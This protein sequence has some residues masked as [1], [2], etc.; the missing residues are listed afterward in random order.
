MTD[1]VDPFKAAPKIVDPFKREPQASAPASPSRSRGSQRK[2][3]QEIAEQRAAQVPE[4]RVVR[5]IDTGMPASYVE[6]QLART[7]EQAEAVADRVAK[8]NAPQPATIAANG[9]GNVGQRVMQAG[10]GA[11]AG[12]LYTAEPILNALGATDLADAAFDRAESMDRYATAQIEGDVGIQEVDSVGDA[13]RFVAQAIPGSLAYMMS[14]FHPAGM[15]ALVTSQTG[16]IGATRAENDGRSGAE[17]G[18]LAIAAPFAAGSVSLDRLGVNR[19][20][21]PA[22]SF[23]GGLGRAAFTE[24]VTEGA[25]GALEYI[26][27]TAGTEAGIDPVQLGWTVAGNTLAGTGMGPAM[28]APIHG[29]QVLQQRVAERQQERA[30]QEAFAPIADDIAR[31][32][33]APDPTLTEQPALPAPKPMADAPQVGAPAAPAAEPVAIVDPF[34]AEQPV[35]EPEPAPTV[36]PVAEPSAEQAAPAEPAPVAVPEPEPAPAPEPAPV[37]APEPAPS[38]DPLRPE[39]GELGEGERLVR[40]P[41]GAQ[42]RTR[43]EVV[44]ASQLAQAEGANQNRDRSRETTDLQVQ[45]II[46]RFDPEQLHEDPSSDRGAPI[47][48][49][50]GA[51]DSG[52]GRVLTLNRIYDAHPDLAAKY[53]AMIEGRGFSTDGMERPV[54]IQ[55]RVTDMTPE[56]RRQFVIDSNKDT[57]LELSPTERARGDADAI[58]PE[59][60]AQYAGGDLNGTANSGFVQAFNKRLTTAELGN[61]I[62]S[63]RRLTT[64]G[65]Q[66]IE[67][68]I[69]AAAFDK[70]KLLERMMESAQ[71][72]IRSITGSLAD[73]A[74]NW[75]RM[76]QDIAAGEVG[77]RYDIT[78]QL[79]DAAARVSDAR[80]RGTKPADII[81]QQDAFDQIDD[82]TEQLIRAFHNPQ[83]TRA[84]SRKAVSGILSDY[85]KIAREQKETDGLFGKE[86]GKAP[87]DI[88]RELLEQRDNPNAGQGL[89]FDSAGTPIAREGRTA[90]RRKRAEPAELDEEGDADSETISYDD[91]R[92]DAAIEDRSPYDP[93]FLTASFTNRASLFHTAAEYLGMDP[94][95]FTLLPAPRQVALLRRVMFERFGVAIKVEGNLQE[96]FAIDQ[97]L[98]AFQNVQA[99]AHILG[100]PNTAVGLDGK[101]VIQ[102]QKGGGYLGAFAPDSNT[103]LL[104]KRT[105]SFAHEWGHALDFFLM[106][107]SGIFG[108]GLTGAI[109]QEGAGAT[110]LTDDMQGSLVRL[111]NAMF[112]DEAEMAAKI[113]QLEA[114]IE[115]SKSPKVKA[116]LQAQ[117]DR[118]KDGSSQSRTARSN[119]YRGAQQADGG[120]RDY[121]TSPTEMF[122]RAFEAYVSYK[123]EEAGLTTE[124]I[125]KGDANY[126][127]NAEDRFRLTFPKDRERAAIFAAFDNLFGVMADAETLGT[128]EAA[129]KPNGSKRS[130]TAYD[131]T[132]AKREELGVIERERRA[133]EAARRQA[134]KEKEDRALDPKGV[135]EK[136]NDVRGAVFMSMTGQLR[137]IQARSKSSALQELIDLLSKQDGKGDRTVKRTFNED[138]QIQS[139]R[140]VNRLANILKA[141]GIAFEGRSKEEDM[142]LRDL[143]TGSLSP[144]GKPGPNAPEGYRAGEPPMPVPAEFVKAAAAI[145]HLLDE[146]FYVNQNA[147]IDLGY[148]RNGYL[149]RTLDM[150]RVWN[151]P[152]GFKQQAAKV[153]EVVFDNRFGKDSDD[154]MNDEDQFKVFMRMARGLAKNGHDIEGL[155]EFRK[156]WRAMSKLRSAA[157]AAA[158]NGDG[159]AA[160]IANGKADAMMDDLAQQ[161]GEVFDQVRT[162]FGIERAELW[163]AKINLVAGEEHNASAPDSEY[164]KHRELPPEA[165]KLME[166]FYVNDP[167]EAVRDYLV[168]SARRTAYARRFGADGK[169]RKKLFERMAAQGVSTEDQMTVERILDTATGRVR[170]QLPRAVEHFLSATHAFGT[171][172]LLPRAVL[173]SLSEPFVSGMVTG[174]ARSGFRLMGDVIAGA[175]RSPNG[176]DRFELARA[177][178][179]VS[180]ASSDDIMLARYG[181]T[182]ADA[183]RWDRYTAAMFSA[184]GLSG[185]TRA[186]KTHAVGLGHAY[187]DNLAQKV[188]NAGNKKAHDDAVALMRELGIRDPEAFSK[189]LLEVGRLPSVDQL[190]TEFGYDYSTA[191]LRFSDMVIQNPSAMDR[192]L[193]S[194]NPVGRVIYGITAFSYGFW[195]NIIKRNGILI[196][197]KWKRD[198][199]Q[200]ALYSSALFASAAM[201][202][203]MGAIISTLREYLLNPKR[204]EDLEREG[205][206]ESTMA[207]LAFTRTFAFGA[208]DI[209]IQT[210]TGLKYQRDPANAFIGAAPGFTVQN[211]TK[212]VSPLQRNSK[213]TNTAEYNATQGA[214]SL[215][216]PVAAFAL[217]RV[218]GGPLITAGKG[219]GMAYVTSPN[220]R[221]LA[222]ETI[223]GKK[224]TRKTKTPTWIDKMRS[225]DDD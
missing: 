84:A 140:A 119:F 48:G 108:K 76:K 7:P 215:M 47:V 79:A 4:R 163:H 45:D 83:L 22:N 209:G 6:Q 121:F 158:K 65:Q 136:L 211:A 15:G 100:L 166:K 160:D 113:M 87:V 182:Y 50:D 104:P 223:W 62:G 28:H 117:I 134:R 32:S 67:N 54:L 161:F 185:L 151:D 180:D 112:F 159:E 189:E 199:G 172:A 154:V 152:A 115:R 78:D 64:A 164:T 157:A 81:A 111:L 44:D 37:T 191:Q 35:T 206:L 25:Q 40:T 20:L 131:K 169:K 38:A 200:A 56:Q 192:P 128:G 27:G 183:T 217:A 105:N 101:L 12:L 30:E 205:E 203:V 51:I 218:P 16:N 137:M 139:H 168:A 129:S 86:P 155:D 220:A 224:D 41:A 204:W 216:S 70:P 18:D 77:G 127:S 9:T 102:F 145:R 90:P 53:R 82:V 5:T 143:L 141:N 109:R 120:S 68:A 148:T 52:N 60:L 219:V 8:L 106:D 196:G 74:P 142:M 19:M 11:G 114:K 58:T 71:D 46:A 178:G 91:G 132:P 184:T 188:M 21:A 197:Q 103:I 31:Q 73:V 156:T 170:S 1:I 130:L 92:P 187:L 146:E 165:D 36:E 94:D 96:R 126:L 99:M 138:V 125:G 175:L 194:Q 181:Q 42:V 61:M 149:R 144:D 10:K 162:A 207:Q 171:M 39:P 75:A 213:K 225:E 122:A 2:R 118:F 43:M 26:G 222:A 201:A 174:D 133:I 202:Y 3:Q 24:G 14:L 93:D 208:A 17:F 33:F 179:I 95:A 212:V 98:D 49:A 85:V 69:V 124:F 147:G 88:L 214:Y 97:M 177:M 72:D 173:S 135:L 59:M 89:M 198:K 190:D 110:A 55:R 186:Q 34:K 123:V 29:A 57:K 80:K 176:K 150:P 153:Y 195:R 66:R 210:W 116:D 193:L 221:D 107:E 63:D 23:L 167:V 13:G